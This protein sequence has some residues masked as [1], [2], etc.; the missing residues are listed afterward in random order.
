[1]QGVVH[2]LLSIPNKVSLDGV[3]EFA[4]HTSDAWR[5]IRAGVGLEGVL[6]LVRPDG[7]ALRTYGGEVQ[8][9]LYLDA[10]VLQIRLKVIFNV[11][12]SLV[13]VF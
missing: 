4:H 13:N 7:M 11:H 2:H 8:G 3:L 12:Y 9:L 1:M 6:N 10:G 5:D